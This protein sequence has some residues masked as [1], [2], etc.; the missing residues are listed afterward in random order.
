MTYAIYCCSCTCLRHYC[1]LLVVTAACCS[2]L[3]F[4]EHCVLLARR[5]LDESQHRYAPVKNLANHF[6]KSLTFHVIDNAVLFTRQ[7]KWSAQVLN[8]F[9]LGRAAKQFPDPRVGHLTTGSFHCRGCLGGGSCV[10]VV[11]TRTRQL[12]ISLGGT[13]R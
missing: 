13:V 10:D 8:F 5:E 11:S 2:T 12:L 9:L 4:L 7:K 1:S 3:L 6:R